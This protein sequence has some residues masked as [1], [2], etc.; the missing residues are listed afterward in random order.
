MVVVAIIGILAA[1]G[2]PSFKTY[3]AK[4]KTA[5][6]RVHLAAIYSA[7]TTFQA[8]FD[9]YSSCLSVM[10]YN[11][12]AEQANRYYAPFVEEIG[13][14][15]TTIVARANGAIS[16]NLGMGGPFYAGKSVG[17]MVFN[18]SCPN[19]GMTLMIG[20]DRA[21][22]YPYVAADGSTFVAG[23]PGYISPTNSYAGYDYW[24]I[25]QS[26]NLVHQKTGY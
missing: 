15:N 7:E 14:G 4:S 5:E 26:K 9:T 25:N 2:I 20:S 13:G 16:C 3:Q 1:V 8:E 21:T 10:G 24:T 6:A 17:A 12:S 19:C 22:P 11:P 23:A 18:T